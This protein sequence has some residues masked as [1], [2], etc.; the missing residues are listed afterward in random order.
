M[1][2]KILI[3]YTSTFKKVFY[4]FYID[5]ESGKEYSV[6]DVDELN[7]KIKELDRIYGHEN[8]RVVLDLDYDVSVS[9]KND[10]MYDLATDEEI[11]NIYNDAFKE[12][13]GEEGNDL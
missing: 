4:Y 9:V 7:I 1:R 2:Y 11:K 13:F 10:S 8:I 3:R 12:V 5:E 6:N